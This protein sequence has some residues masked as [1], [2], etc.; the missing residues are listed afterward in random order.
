M[1]DRLLLRLAGIRTKRKTRAGGCRRAQLHQSHFA[2]LDHARGPVK[3]FFHLE[4]F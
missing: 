1:R 4:G 3:G 2:K